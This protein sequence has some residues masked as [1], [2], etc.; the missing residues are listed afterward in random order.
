ME[1][2]EN[3]SLACSLSSGYGRL[4]FLLLRGEVSLAEG[5]GRHDSVNGAK[6]RGRESNDKSTQQQCLPEILLGDGNVGGGW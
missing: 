3:S 6:R 1:P 2:S 5:R 4:S